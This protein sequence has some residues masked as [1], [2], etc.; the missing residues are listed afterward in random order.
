MGVLPT[1]LRITL[2]GEA[3]EVAAPCSVADLL[4]LLGLDR[5][6]VAVERNLEI[7]PRSTYAETRLAAGDAL[8]I[9]HFIGGG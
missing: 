1:M 5:R 6:K 2:N 3:R 9:V 7:V 8:E 4:D